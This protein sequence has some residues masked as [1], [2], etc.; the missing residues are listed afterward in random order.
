MIKVKEGLMND[1]EF[2]KEAKKKAE[3][4]MLA[5]VDELCRG[6]FYEDK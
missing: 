3:K 2:E 1:G 6:I 4:A 5:F